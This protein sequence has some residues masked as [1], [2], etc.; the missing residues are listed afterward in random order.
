MRVPLAAFAASFGALLLLAGSSGA[1]PG[2]DTSPVRLWTVSRIDQGGGEQQVKDGAQVG[3]VLQEFVRIGRVV[4]N[5]PLPEPYWSILPRDRAF[6]ALHSSADGKRY[7]VL[8]TAPSPNPLRVGSVTGT[9]THLDEYQAYVKQ[10]DD[11]T[12]RITI[13]GLLLNI[14]DGNASPAPWEC[15]AAAA[16]QF[17]RTVVRV[18]ARAYAVSA[19][20]D[21]FDAGGVAYLE[22]RKHTWRLGAATSADSPGPLWG[23]KDFDVDP[24]ADGSDTGS[25]ALMSL[26][27]SRTLTVPLDSVRT[28]ELFAVHVSLEAEAVDERPGEAAA[29]AAIQDPQRLDTALLSTHGLEARGRPGF[30]EPPV[31]ALAPASCPGGRPAGAG[32]VQLSD[33][34]FT[35]DES[36]R[37]PLVLVTRT[38]G[39]EG[40]ASVRVTARGGTATPGRDFVAT[41]TTVRFAPGETSP[42]LVEIPLREDRQVEPAETFTVELD[43]PRCVTLG[44]RRSATVTI[45]DDDQVPTPPA[46]SPTLPPPTPSPAPPAPGGTPAPPPPAAF[47]LGGTVD[48][49][50]GAGLVL[51][52][53]GS[54][55][56]VAANGPF[57]FPGTRAAG[58]PY[59]VAVRTQPHGPDQ[60]CTVQHGAGTVGSADVTDVVVHCETPAAPAGLDLSFGGTGRVS[61]P[62]GGDGEGEAVVIQPGGDI[63]TAGWRSTAGGNDFAL[64]RHDPTGQLDHGFG[65]DGIVTTDLGG[66]NDQ[67]FDAALLPDG[68][69][70]VAGRTDAAGILKTAFGVVRY[71]A[72]GAPDPGFGTSG[73]VELGFFGKGAGANAVAV[74]PDGKILVAGFAFDASGIDSDF[75]LVRLEPD[76]T[77]DPGFGTGG[78]VTTNLGTA[79]DDARAV[80]VQPDGRIV[81]AG[82]ADEDIALVR[83]LPDGTLDSSFGHGG[84]TITNLG[85]DDVANGVALTPAG[86]ILIAGYTLGAGINRDF[87]LGRYRADGTLVATVKTDVSG[88]DDFAED[89]AVDDRGRIVLVGRA[90]SSTI[91]DMA[92]VRYLPDGSLDTSFDGDGI[93]TADFHGRGEFGQD[94][95]LDSDGR[96]V[97]AGYTAN[98]GDTE[99]ALLRANP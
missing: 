67:A 57:T 30:D 40:S 37:E 81:V 64:T 41:T 36:E 55:V 13:S 38:G 70:V 87:L 15:P 39:S 77:L 31:K 60:V 79:A 20:G 58:Q 86:E 22:G 33:P 95:A 53:L 44:A 69:I 23:Q 43:R 28:G 3:G 54:D 96:I 75:A 91:L 9:V 2:P 17:L 84:S 68:G 62:V 51:T 26:H 1:A 47:T 85:S 16:C 99:F 83:Y 71:R 59:E 4:F 50:R 19:G 78:I 42:R 80:V 92:L 48:G 6:G 8:A 5:L 21:F 45:V 24:D 52:D 73:I 46:P 89:L 74:Q 76:G 72:D 12:L 66:P 7:S 18:H 25:D 90:T 88:G 61:T 10:A 63:V 35:V 14:V 49:L 65:T 94:V 56:A 32:V 97:A 11:A 98:G 82:S 34:G 27:D 93:L 29:Q